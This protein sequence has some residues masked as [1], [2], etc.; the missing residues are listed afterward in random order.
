MKES[1]YDGFPGAVAKNGII[2]PIG[3]KARKVDVSEA[4]PNATR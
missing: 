1:P 2:P 3:H 4:N